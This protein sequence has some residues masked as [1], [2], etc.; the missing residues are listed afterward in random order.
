MIG[1]RAD[2]NSII[3]T[4]H[5]FRCFAIAEQLVKM[6]ETVLFLVAD[7]RPCELIKE[8]GY[9]SIVLNTEWTKLE[10]EVGRLIEVVHEY[11]IDTLLID[12]YYAT[13]SYFK[14]IRRHVRTAY[15]DDKQAADCPV[16]ILVN[17]MAY[18][19][20][21][22]YRI[23]SDTE[24]YIGTEYT[25]LRSQFL[26]SFENISKSHSILILTGGTDPF[27]IRKK[28]T[29]AILS[30]KELEKYN[31]MVV[32]GIYDDAEKI[33]SRSDRIQFYHNVNNMAK[34]MN[35]A[36]FAVTAAG[37][38]LYELCA[39]RLPAVSYSFADTHIDNARAF[40]ALGAIPYAGDIRNDG[41]ET[42]RKIVDKLKNIDSENITATKQVMEK[43]VDKNGAKR[44]AE[45][46]IRV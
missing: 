24:Y 3:G 46:L 44:I 31:L 25:P 18:A 23:K 27:S 42:I 34:L 40:D 28:L 20:K 13:E 30:E 38:T 26:N 22:K 41:E 9:D 15:I 16:D 21:R 36:E 39:M 5:L 29:K 19:D 14:K 6:E 35:Q 37:T 8:K 7:E 17:Y 32:S 33:I 12:T 11:G 43:L 4:G 1:I 45:I 10:E 2:G